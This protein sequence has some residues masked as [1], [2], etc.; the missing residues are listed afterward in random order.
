[1]IVDNLSN[2]K[3]TVVDHIATLTGKR[4]VFYA[5]DLADAEGMEQIFRSHQ[6]EGVLH[7]AARKAVGESCHDPRGYY[8][9]NITTL[10]QLTQL[11]KKY[12]VVRFI[13]S[14]SCTVYDATRTEAPFS[15]DAPTGSC[16]SPY[17]TTKAVGEAILRDLAVHQGFQ[18]ASLR[19]FNP[20]GAHPSGLLGEDPA[21]PP[22]NLLPVIFQVL[23]GKR[24]LLEIFGDD[25]P[26]PDGS[27]LRDY[28]H[29]VDLAQAHLAARDRLTEQS[30]PCFVPINIGTG[31]PTSVY[32]LVAI[33]EEVTTRKVTYK[34]VPR[35]PG[36]LPV[37]YALPEQAQQLLGR[38]AQRSV[39]DAVRDGRHF[40]QHPPHGP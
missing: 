15:E 13:F 33:V 11:M 24:D 6:L 1:M 10:V 7:F 21:Q 16:S 40:V 14:S 30:A 9:N 28:I 17:G 31:T 26:T 29:V 20:I 8:A 36:D 22:T 34:T 39:T 27:C 38:T 2:S 25:Y 32:E 4:P 35:R 18:I 12:E 3:S 19:Y 5:T 37:A 23:D